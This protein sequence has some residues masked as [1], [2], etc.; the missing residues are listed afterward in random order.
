MLPCSS[1]VAMYRQAKKKAGDVRG[2]CV[3]KSACLSRCACLRLIWGSHEAVLPSPRLPLVC[4]P[5]GLSCYIYCRR[6]HGATQG[7]GRL[8]AALVLGGWAAEGPRTRYSWRQIRVFVPV[9]ASSRFRLIRSTVNHLQHVRILR[10]R[11]GSL[12]PSNPNAGL[13]T[14]KQTRKNG[15]SLHIPT[16]ASPFL[17]LK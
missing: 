4:S 15:P 17:T 13:V 1:V 7:R 8:S 11:W 12:R 14:R 5:R 9:G 16:F 3:M 2:E 10:D 6:G